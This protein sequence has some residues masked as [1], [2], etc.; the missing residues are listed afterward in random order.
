[1]RETWK[2]GVGYSPL[3][4]VGGSRPLV[5][6]E[7]CNIN[8]P[9]L[10]R[11]SGSGSQIITGRSYRSPSISQTLFDLELTRSKTPSQ[12]RVDIMLQGDSK[13]RLGKT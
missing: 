5:G 13:V 12:P 8:T 10:G 2:S 6:T 3:G 1:M 7:R 4:V 9:P 11:A